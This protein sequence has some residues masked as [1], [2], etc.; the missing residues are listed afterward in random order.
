M[1][2]PEKFE[3]YVKKGTIRKISPDKSRAEF[4]INESKNSLEGLNER[5]EKLG[6]SDKN[7]TIK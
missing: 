3:E 5:V 6:I 7:A 2:L 1:K 4:L